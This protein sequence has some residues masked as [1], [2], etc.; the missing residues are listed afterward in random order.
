MKIIIS[1]SKTMNIRETQTT[2]TPIFYEKSKEI[3]SHLKNMTIEELKQ[4]W[5]TND[6]LT[7]LNYEKLHSK[8]AIKTPALLAYD[9]LK[10]KNIKAD[11]LCEEEIN[12]LNE[13]LII[14]SG[15]Y[16]M[17]KP[18]DGIA[19][20]RL[21]MQSKIS[22]SDKNNLYEYWREDVEKELRGNTILNLASNEYSKLIKN[23][24]VVNCVF[25]SEDG[26]K[27]KVKATEAKI[28]R[29]TMV[30]FIAKNKIRNLEEVKSFSLLNYSFSDKLS[31]EDD[32]IFIKK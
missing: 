8:E 20:H 6:K 22:I 17:L 19:H 16:G 11:T 18:M 29:G 15:F 2:S 3:E 24:P 14:L 7:T 21:E 30:N 9:G 26:E 31:S 25:A 5:K 13:C 27:I 1:E 23:L 28:A 32:Y 4:L 12:H 10:F